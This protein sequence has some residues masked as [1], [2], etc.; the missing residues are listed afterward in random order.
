MFS[1]GAGGIETLIGKDCEIKGNLYS[2]NTIRIDGRIEGN[3]ESAEWVIVGEHAAVKG[4]VLGKQ[5]VI[6]GSVTGDVTARAKLEIL[7]TGRVYGD[8]NTPRLAMAEGVIFEG[9]CEME[10]AG[11]EKK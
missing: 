2:K 4:D 10:A 1:K 7:H 11:V 8:L 6:G 9:S 5:V 3:I